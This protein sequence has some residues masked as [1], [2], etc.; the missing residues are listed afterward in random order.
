MMMMMMMATYV[1]SHKQP[2]KT[3]NIS[4]VLL[5]KVR[6]NSETAFFYELQHMKTQVFIFTNPSARAGYN[7]NRVAVFISSDDNHYTSIS[8]P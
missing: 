3:S 1:Q 5:E 8:R 2:K 7:L 6:T 4:K